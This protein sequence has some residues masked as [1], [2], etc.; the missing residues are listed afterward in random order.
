MQKPIEQWK[1]TNQVIEKRR[2]QESHHDDVI[3]DVLLNVD[4][5]SVLGD[6]LPLGGGPAV[7]AG[8]LAGG[9]VGVLL[10]VLEDLGEGLGGDIEGD[11]A[12]GATVVDHVRQR[13]RLLRHRLIH[14]LLLPVRAPRRYLLLR[15]LR[16]RRHNHPSDPS[17]RRNPRTQDPRDRSRSSSQKP[18][19]LKTETRSGAAYLTETGS[20]GAKIIWREKSLRIAFFY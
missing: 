2:T 19:K 1:K 15:I 17:T 9:E 20:L 12:L 4:V 6:G 13:L 10:A 14:L 11:P 3:E 7:E 8:G 18:R 16:R 5:V